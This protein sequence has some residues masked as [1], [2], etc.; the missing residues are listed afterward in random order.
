MTNSMV[1]G[2]FGLATLL[3]IMGSGAKYKFKYNVEGKKD[4]SGEFFFDN[5]YKYVGEWVDDVPHG[6]GCLLKQN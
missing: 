1:L 4:G 2:K 5:G 6:Q 3:Y